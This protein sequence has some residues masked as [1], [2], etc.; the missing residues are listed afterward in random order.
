[1][2][3]AQPGGA[4]AC[5]DVCTTAREIGHTWRLLGERDLVHSEQ[6]EFFG[7]YQV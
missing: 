2:Y 1:M 4:A 5:E 3:A 6:R 7:A